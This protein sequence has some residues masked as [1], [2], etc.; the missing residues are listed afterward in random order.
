[1]KPLPLGQ[2]VGAWLQNLHGMRG[3]EEE[4]TPLVVSPSSYWYVSGLNATEC[5]SFRLC[6]SLQPRVV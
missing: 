2:L 3:G 4:W 1:M 6:P 5:V